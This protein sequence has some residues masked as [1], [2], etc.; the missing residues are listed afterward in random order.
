MKRDLFVA[1]WK[2]GAEWVGGTERNGTRCVV[3]PKERVSQ[4]RQR[5]REEGKQ[6]RR[7]AHRY[8]CCLRGVVLKRRSE[9]ERE[10]EEEEADVA[11]GVRPR[12]NEVANT[13]RF[14]CTKQRR[15]KQ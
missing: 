2:K 3:Y 11:K 8:R 14:T 12:G 7:S 1:H 9:G 15:E 13:T 4:R 6:W 5:A 10:G